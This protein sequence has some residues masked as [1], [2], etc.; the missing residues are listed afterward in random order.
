LNADRLDRVPFIWDYTEEIRARL[1]AEFRPQPDIEW[2]KG[3]AVLRLLE[4]LNLDRPEAVPIYLGDD[5]T[6]DDAL[7]ALRER[8]IGIVMR[9]EDDIAPWRRAILRPSAPTGG[10]SSNC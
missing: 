5:P 10:A 3:R 6:E 9:G 7:I 4:R 1:G 2:N 8:R